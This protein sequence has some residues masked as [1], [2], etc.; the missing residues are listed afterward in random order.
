VQLSEPRTVEL[1]DQQIAFLRTSLD[2]SAQR[3]RDHDY[4]QDETIRKFG[5]ERRA[6]ADAVI[7][8]IRAAFSRAVQ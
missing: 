8:S 7:A 3:F 4:G 6:E 5:I 2:Y 1:T